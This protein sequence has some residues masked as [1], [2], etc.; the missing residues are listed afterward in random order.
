MT[1]VKATAL[2]TTVLAV[3]LQRDFAKITIADIIQQLTPYI[4]KEV[5]KNDGLFLKKIPFVKNEIEGYK[6]NRYGFDFWVNQHYYLTVKYGELSAHLSTTVSGGG[7]D[8]IGVNANHNRQE[9]NFYLFKVNGN[10]LGELIQNDYTYLNEMFYVDAILKIEE[11]V[12]AA[13]KEY[14][15]VCDKMPHYFKNVLYIK[16]I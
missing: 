7:Y 14:E 2:E 11:E 12:K 9:N 10:S 13:A 8:L 4:G 6:I 3:N 5:F 15:R 1:K 16:N